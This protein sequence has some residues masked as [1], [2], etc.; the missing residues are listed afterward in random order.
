MPFDEDFLARW[1]RRKVEDRSRSGSVDPTPPRNPT[2]EM[3]SAQESAVEPVPDLDCASLEFSDFSRFVRNG[4]SDTLQTAALRRLWSSSPM[5]GSSDGLDVYRADYAGACRLADMPTA[6]SQAL[7]M[8][9]VEQ[10]A[11]DRSATSAPRTDVA[12]DT[13]QVSS[14]SPEPQEPQ[15]SD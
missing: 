10:C 8:V 14:P 3:N 4:V 12:A 1:S 2:P 11:P 9:A 15:S 13:Q 7:Q 6:V 5:F